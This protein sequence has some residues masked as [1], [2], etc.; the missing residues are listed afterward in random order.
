MI[1]VCQRISTGARRPCPPLLK[2]ADNALFFQVATPMASYSSCPRARRVRRD[3]LR[4]APGGTRV[5]P[6][7]RGLEIEC[8]VRAMAQRGFNVFNN[9]W[10]TSE[11]G[12]QTIWARSFHN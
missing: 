3:C 6:P 10:N 8:P 5:H 11:A 2:E 7:E 9:E 1:K 12:P 4:Y